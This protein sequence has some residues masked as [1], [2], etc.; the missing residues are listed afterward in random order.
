MKILNRNELAG[1]LQPLRAQGKKIVFT[2]G[3]FDILHAGH[4]RYL[5]AA[6]ELGDYLLVGLNSDASV[7]RLKGPER[8]LN[9]QDDR[10]EVLAGLAAVDGVVIFEDETAEGL[11]REIQPEVYVK[12][13]DYQVKNLPEADIVAGY[14][15]Q[16][17]LLPEVPGRSSSNVIRK[18]RQSQE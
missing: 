6:R 3:C 17:V 13:G 1:A 7:R 2:N 10:A 18:I 12:G 16:T 9:T 8:P 5:A 14:G 11:V 4:V 15:G